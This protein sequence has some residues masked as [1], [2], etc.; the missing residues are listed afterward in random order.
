MESSEDKTTP[1]WYAI[2]RDMIVCK[3]AYLF[4]NAKQSCYIPLMILFFESIGLDSSRAGLINGLRY[5]GYLIGSPFWGYLADRKQAHRFIIT[6]LCVLAVITMCSQPFLSLLVG[7]Q[8][9]QKCPTDSNL[10]IFHNKTFN[11]KMNRTLN[12]TVGQSMKSK[13]NE[14]HLFYTMLSIN[15]VASFFDGSTQSFMDTGVMRRVLASPNRPKFGNQRYFGAIGYGGGALL[16]SVV[17]DNFPSLNVTCYSGLFCVYLF[18]TSGLAVISNILFKRIKSSNPHPKGKGEVRGILRATLCKPDTLFFLATVLFGG[19]VHA[20]YVSFLFVFLKELD[21]PQILMGLSITV[22]AVFGLLGFICAAKIIKVV[23]GTMNLLCF[24]CFVWCIRFFC[25]AYTYNPWLVLP[26]QLTHGIG[27][28]AFIAACVEHTR[29]IS[30]PAILAT[31][32]GIMNSLYFGA[33]F[34]IANIGGGSLYKYV[35]SR[36]TFVIASVSC[37]VWAILVFIYIVIG[38][39]RKKAKVGNVYTVEEAQHEMN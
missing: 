7:D 28:A 18:F 15:I 6:F 39:Y 33:S 3:I 13:F 25:Y 9:K 38:I 23:G 26:T 10:E 24:A 36:Q 21:S 31:M 17:I 34:V 11:V 20:F 37:G 14:N 2:D 19:T 16:S 29:M 35:G 32:Y 30:A 4:E 12:E 8:E 27:F 1:K 5:I 22:A